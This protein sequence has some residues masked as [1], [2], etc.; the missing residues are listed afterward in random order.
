MIAFHASLR[1]GG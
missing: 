1:L